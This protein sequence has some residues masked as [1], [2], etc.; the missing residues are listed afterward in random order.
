MTM[1]ASQPADAYAIACQHI[2]QA[3]GWW[4]FDAFMAWALYDPQW[5]YYLQ[6]PEHIWGEQGDYVTAPMQGDWLARALSQ[7]LLPV[8]Q[9]HPEAALL[10][11]GPGRGDLQRDV[12]KQWQTASS[13]PSQVVSIEHNAPPA[14]AKPFGVLIANEVLDALPVQRFI[15]SAEGWQTLGVT[16]QAG[17]LSLQARALSSTDE[18][19][20][21]LEHHFADRP[22]GF[23]C[24]RMANLPEAFARWSASLDSG[25]M[26]FL[27]YGGPLNDCYPQGHEAG[28]LHAFYQ[29]QVHDD[30]LVH[31]GRQDLT[32]WVDFSY[33]TEVA[34]AQGWGCHGFS[35]QAQFLLQQLTSTIDST[36]LTLADQQALH[37]LLLPGEMG[38]R[39]K[40]LALTKN[41]PAKTASQ[42]RLAERDFSYRL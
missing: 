37:T 42:L 16:Q 4:R 19:H 7:F 39:V 24:E 28:R 18:H 10:E 40:V 35:T 17:A 5:G 9:A 22:V 25:V 20:A 33:V 15:K 34:A 26:V 6:P 8:F 14:P 23:Q 31:L 21:W 36:E 29:H 3:A 30:A 32:A 38:E 41:L 11:L 27:D 1:T 12:L 13:A 2:N